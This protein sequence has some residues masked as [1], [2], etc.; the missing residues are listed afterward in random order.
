MPPKKNKTA[1]EASSSLLDRKPREIIPFLRP[2]VGI[3]MVDHFQAYPRG[4]IPA[5]LLPHALLTS[6][7]AGL[8]PWVWFDDFWQ[9][10]DGMYPLNT[11][12]VEGKFTSTGDILPG[13]G[14]NA[15]EAKEHAKARF[16]ALSYSPAPPSAAENDASSTV[17][18]F[19]EDDDTQESFERRL[20]TT[21]RVALD[22]LKARVLS[23]DA[24]AATLVL[25][26][27]PLSFWRMQI[28]TQMEQSF[29]MQVGTGLAQ[30]GE[31][32]DIKRIFLEGNPLLLAITMVV[33]ALHSVFDFLAFK[34]DIGFWKENKSLE[35]LSAR[36]VLLN[37]FSQLVIFLYL[38]DNDTSMVVLFSAGAGTAIEFWKITKAFD[39]ELR[40]FG[41]F[42]P[43]KIKDR[44]SYVESD[45]RKHDEVAM[46]YLSYV[47]LPL[48]AGYSIYALVYESHKSWYSWALGSLVGAVYAFGFILMCPQLYLNYKLKSVAH[49]PWRQMT[50]K[51]LNTIIDDLF[52]FVIKM[53]LLHRLSVFRDDVVFLVY[54]YQ[55]WIYRVDPK[56]ANEFGF[57]AEDLERREREKKE[58]VDK[59]RAKEQGVVEGQAVAAGTSVA[60]AGAAAGGALRQR[61]RADGEEDS[62]EKKGAAGTSAAATAGAAGGGAVRQR[63]KAEEEEEEEEEED[64]KEGDEKKDR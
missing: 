53:P 54:L 62:E 58:E 51:F 6:D 39:V 43:V 29:K 56:R 23:G 57:S 18:A 50:Y 27:N 46:R 30:E 41:S 33:S 35:G 3:A 4:A 64:K 59:A 55:R 31:S 60:A 8:L 21:D 36:S 13:F 32:D 45:T 34:N 44:A 11:S 26:L 17:I 14:G 47:L 15:T 19:D 40:P 12:W 28:Y 63:R 1:K 49:L 42:P 22:R 24:P 7:G 9:L 5:P 10:R 16:V 38:L 52:A 37:A 61:R 48:V 25:T 20:S 2:G